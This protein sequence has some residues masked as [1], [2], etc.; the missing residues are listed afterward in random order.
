[1]WWLTNSRILKNK[2]SILLGITENREFSIDDWLSLDIDRR[3]I[4]R[5]ILTKYTYI[6]VKEIVSPI[7]EV[8]AS[9]LIGSIC[10]AIIRQLLLNPNQMPHEALRLHG[11]GSMP[12]S[13]SMT[14]C[15][16]EIREIRWRT[17]WWHWLVK[18]EG[19]I[20]D[21]G[22]RCV[23]CEEQN[24]KPSQTLVIQSE[25]ESIPLQSICDNGLGHSGVAMSINYD[26]DSLTAVDVRNFP[27][28]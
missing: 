8:G 6:L 14:D 11:S 16:I 18:G 1:M 3:S 27:N 26:N 19:T 28:Q 15:R 21:F 23:R 22:S 12:L 9:H 10:A 25:G 4:C 20:C 2:H 13:L 24:S 5:R 17:W 7:H